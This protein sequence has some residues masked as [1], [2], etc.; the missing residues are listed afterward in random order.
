[1]IPHKADS[2]N[3]VKEE[4][5]KRCFDQYYQS[6]RTYAFGIV[7]DDDDAKEIVQNVF[8]ELWNNI[9]SIDIENNIAGYLFISARW[10]CLRV[11]ELR[12]YSNQY[13]KYGSDTGNYID[14]T[15]ARNSNIHSIWNSELM[16]I[17]SKTL[18]TLPDKTR[19]AFV[20][21]KFNNFSHQYIAEK[22]NCSVKNIE[23][24][25]SLAIK[26]LKEALKDYLPA[27]LLGIFTSRWF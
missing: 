18:S 9:D 4:I 3:S 5:F 16:D 25:M 26:A 15:I 22:Q 7:K 12:K 8:M 27:I 2:V 23:Y 6:I 17:V 11:I 13:K 14:Y 24:R 21:N 1:M 19:E 10:K 20:M